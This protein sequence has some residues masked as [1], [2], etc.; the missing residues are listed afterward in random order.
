MRNR[1]MVGLIGTVLATGAIVAGG[2][3]SAGAVGSDDAIAV[4][5]RG[6]GDDGPGDDNGGA[7]DR[8]REVRHAGTCTVRS[9][10]KIK[11][12]E[13]DGGRLEVEFEVDQ[14]RNGQK[15]GV[16]LKRNGSVVARTS[17]LTKAP[18]GSFSVERLIGDRAGADTVT[19]VARNTNTGETC[20][21]RV[22]LA[23]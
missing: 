2:A 9:T 6:G 21:A 11:V 13:E 16:V 1:T 12:K 15:W 14:N 17:A 4:H 20:T 10:S 3:V 23:A 7:R 18:S 8:G 22:V 19:G 5:S